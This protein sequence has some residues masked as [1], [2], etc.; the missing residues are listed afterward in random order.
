[1][2]QNCPVTIQDIKNSEVIFGPPVASLKGKTTRQAPDTVTSNYFEVTR[3]IYNKHKNV[4]LCADIFFVQRIPFL[5]Q[6]QDI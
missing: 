6:C 3:Y 2:L 1:M 4:T 5:L